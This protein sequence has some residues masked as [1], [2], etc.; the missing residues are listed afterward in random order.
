[1]AVGFPTKV[2]YANGDVYSAGDVNDTN[3]TLNLLN[4][5]AKGSLVSASAANTPS[6]LAVGTDGHV[7]TADSTAATGLKWAAATSGMTLLNT[8]TFSA[9]SSQI[10]DSLFSSTYQNY[11]IL[12]TISAVSGADVNINAYPRSAGADVTTNL[13]TEA[14]ANNSTTVTGSQNLNGW[15]LVKS[16]SAYPAFSAAAIDL[17]N[18]QIARTT[19]FTTNGGYVTAAGTPFQWRAYGYNGSSTQMTGIKFYPSSGTMSGE[20]SI[21]GLAK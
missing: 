11:R 5:T 17:F 21:Y 6:R 14:V 13:N 15:L 8:T 1:M 9:V 18:P 3:G 4:P 19:S 7:L 12:L 16:T 20:V 10:I 2:T